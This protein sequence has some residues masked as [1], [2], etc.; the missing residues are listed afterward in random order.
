MEYLLKGMEARHGKEIFT[1][2]IQKE[3]FN[4][5]KVGEKEE[6]KIT[7]RRKLKYAK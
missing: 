5:Y 3:K 4:D 7:H 1:C 6:C 2:I